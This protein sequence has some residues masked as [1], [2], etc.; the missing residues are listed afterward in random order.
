MGGHCAIIC[1]GC[2]K[3][4]NIDKFPAGTIGDD[5]IKEE[6]EYY[7]KEDGLLY[8]LRNSFIVIAFLN[9]HQSVGC[10]VQIVGGDTHW[11]LDCG[12]AEEVEIDDDI[13]PEEWRELCQLEEKL[14]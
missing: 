3:Y 2:K 10:N 14:C 9:L 12:Y 11:D 8:A 1:S 6:L 4:K 7:I 13:S 5:S